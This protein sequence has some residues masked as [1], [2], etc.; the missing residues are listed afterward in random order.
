MYYIYVQIKFMWNVLYNN[1]SII[2]RMTAR[3][4]SWREIALNACTIGV[5]LS[6]FLFFS[7]SLSLFLP[8][9]PLRFAYYPEWCIAFL[10][11]EHI[12]GLVRAAPCR[13][14]ADSEYGGAYVFHPC[15]VF[16]NTFATETCNRAARRLLDGTDGSR[17]AGANQRGCAI[18]EFALAFR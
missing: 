10:Q 5:A 14:F 9:V 11:C 16:V 15:F 2:A 17:T 3:D 7:L 8:S 1:P 18:L 4:F 13:A 12:R 6:L